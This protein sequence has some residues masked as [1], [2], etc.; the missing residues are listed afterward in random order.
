MLAKPFESAEF[1]LAK[2]IKLVC[3]KMIDLI[4]LADHEKIDLD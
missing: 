4:A 3:A 1:T 2:I